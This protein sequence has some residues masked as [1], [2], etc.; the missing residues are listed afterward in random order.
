MKPTLPLL[1]L[2]L[3]AACSHQHD[4]DHH[5]HDDAKLFLSAY[6]EHFEVFVE[7]DPFAVGQ[8]AAI[9]VHLTSLTDFKPVTEAGITAS[10]ITGNQGIRQRTETEVRPGIYRLVLQPG[11]AG[12]SRL[13]IDIRSGDLQE[14]LETEPILVFDDA[15]EAIHSAEDAMADIP[16]AVVFTKEQSWAIDFA[17][18]KANRQVF[19]PVITTVGEV[20]AD[21]DDETLLNARTGGMVSFAGKTLYP[22]LGVTANEVLLSIT[23]G[24]LAEGNAALRYREAKN[25]YERAGADL[26]RMETLNTERIVS[27]RDLLQAQNAYRNAE[28][29]YSNLRQHFTESGQVVLSPWGG[30]IKE[31]YVTEGEYVHMGQPIARIARDRNLVIRA[32]VRQQFT[33]LLS[34]ISQANIGLSGQQALALEHWQGEMISVGR[35]IDPATGMLPVHIRVPAAEGLLPGSLVDVYLKAETSQKVLVVPNTALIEEQGNYFVFVQN[36]PESFSKRQVQTGK[37][38]GRLTEV[39]AGLQENERIVTR[40]AVMVRLAAASGD[41]DPHSGHVH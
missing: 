15:H 36:H 13:V 23:G 2:L 34:N 27:D 20:M 10:L 32:G 37:T 35:S 11:S 17:T 25:N 40:G 26:R 16:G 24:D 4:H 12:H 28:A 14:T 39:A 8:N 9:A 30:Y 29:I 5:H 1:L 3:I 21:R 41:L 18:R 22:G 33:G 6:G 38:D 7:A 19:G 31:L